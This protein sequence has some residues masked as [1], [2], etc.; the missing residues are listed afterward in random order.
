[1]FLSS[2]SYFYFII[3]GGKEMDFDPFFYLY[4]SPLLGHLF[5]AAQT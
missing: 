4:I 1:M 5:L 2:F 3:F